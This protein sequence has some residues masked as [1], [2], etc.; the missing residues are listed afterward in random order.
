[1]DSQDRESLRN[2]DGVRIFVDELNPESR[3]LQVSRDDIQRVV[4]TRLRGAG[5]TVLTTGH[6]PVGDPFL[7][8]YVSVT[9]EQQRLVAYHVVVDFIQLAFLRRNPQFIYNRAQTWKASER[10]EMVPAAQL[11]PSVQRELIRQVDEY[12]AAYRSVNSR[13]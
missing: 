9:A 11:S 5:I 8:V 7:R 12:I 4:E 3:A 6:F 2:L 13:I 10:M 1:M